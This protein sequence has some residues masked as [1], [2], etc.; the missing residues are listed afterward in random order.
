MRTAVLS[1][2]AIVALCMVAVL[3]IAGILTV[4]LNEQLDQRGLKAVV[5]QLFIKQE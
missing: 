1:F 5:E 2:V 3:I 4:E